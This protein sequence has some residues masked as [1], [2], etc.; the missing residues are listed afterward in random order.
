MSRS[1]LDS[2]ISWI[3]FELSK[4][5]AA[6]ARQKSVSKSGP[7]PLRV[8]HREPSDALARPAADLAAVLDLLQ[9]PLRDNDGR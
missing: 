8:R 1:L 7:V 4:I 6:S 5:A 9:R 3:F 2:E